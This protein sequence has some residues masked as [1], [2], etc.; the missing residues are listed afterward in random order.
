M[1]PPTREKARTEFNEAGEAVTSSAKPSEEKRRSPFLGRRPF[2]GRAKI[3]VEQDLPKPKVKIERAPELQH[4]ERQKRKDGSKEE[5]LVEI[6]STMESRSDRARKVSPERLKEKKFTELRVGTENLDT[7]VCIVENIAIDEG[8]GGRPQGDVQNREERKEQMDTS[9][10]LSGAKRN[11][12]E[13][14]EKEGKK[15]KPNKTEEEKISARNL[16]GKS[17]EGVILVEEKEKSA[18]IGQK[19]EL[20]ASNLKN[21]ETEGLRKKQSDFEKKSEELDWRNRSEKKEGMDQSKKSKAKSEKEKAIAME[22]SECQTFVTMTSKT[23]ISSKD[24]VPSRWDCSLTSDYSSLNSSTSSS[25][26]L[27]SV[28]SPPPVFEAIG[29]GI[30]IE[31]QGSAVPR[32]SCSAEPAKKTEITDQVEKSDKDVTV[33]SGKMSSAFLT[34]SLNVTHHST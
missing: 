10:K 34:F 12:E 26:T 11:S 24:E 9:Q 17:E 7:E 32:Q 5:V 13:K 20:L 30:N 15:R 16:T 31:D 4:Q 18:P 6:S 19:S 2:G 1:V 22:I 21:D 25:R 14:T 3:L 27:N 28:Q 8:D 23:G 29:K 33:A